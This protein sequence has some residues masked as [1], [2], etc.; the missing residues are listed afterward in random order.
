M[1]FSSLA[2]GKID[3]KSPDAINSGIYSSKNS[4]S[5]IAK[6]FAF[7]QSSIAQ[8]LANYSSGQTGKYLF[9]SLSP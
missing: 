2:L 3:N 9:P 7:D 1:L 8:R 4:S 6:G 5:S